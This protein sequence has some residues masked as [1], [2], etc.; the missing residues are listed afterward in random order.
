MSMII[1]GRSAGK[2]TPAG[3]RRAG[4]SQLDVEIIG[5]L[6]ALAVLCVLA[7]LIAPNFATTGNLLDV[8]RQ[9]AFT[10]I[11]ACGMTL[12]I[13]AGEIDISVGSAIAFASALFG[14]SSQPTTCRSGPRR[15]PSS[16]PARRLA[17]GPC[18]PISASP[19]S[20]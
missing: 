1:E 10:G 17:P 16:S 7:A 15:W 19:P 14:S 12:V 13:I 20:S 4:R 6:A 2:S 18:A 3:G 5:L 11:I 8:L 9:V